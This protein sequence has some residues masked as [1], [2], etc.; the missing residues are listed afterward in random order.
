MDASQSLP[1][2]ILTTLS[3]VAQSAH[4]LVG[5]IRDVPFARSGLDPLTYELLDLRTILERLLDEA[6][7]PSPLRA[8]VLALLI[9]C[10]DV[11][12]RIDTVLSS[13]GGDGTPRSTHWMATAKD[14]SRGL[15]GE[16]Q[17]CRRAMRLA[18]EMVNLY[19][20]ESRA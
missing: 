13:C 6:T 11:L 15:K 4:S 5:F 19:V 10:R 16:L 17:A 12:A 2:A 18:L 3:A 1:A 20:R 14:E 9:A 7:I 8:P